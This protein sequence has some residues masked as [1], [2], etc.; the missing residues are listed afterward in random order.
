MKNTEN[1]EIRENMTV[2]LDGLQHWKSHIDDNKIAYWTLD[3]ADASVNTLSIDVMNEL[4]KLIEVTENKSSELKGV[5]ITSGKTSGF[6]AGADIQQFTVMTTFDE[7]FDII[8]KGQL[9]FE[10][11]S[12]L[13]L[14]TVA[15]INGF[16]MGGGTELSLACDY[17]IAKDDPKTRIGLPEVKLGI[18]PG[19]G[20]TIRL[21][22]LMGVLNAMNMILTGNPVGIKEALRTGLIDAAVPERYLAI[23][24]KKMIL[25][26]P[27]PHHPTWLEKLPNQK[28]L[29]KWV[30]KLLRKKVSKHVRK[31]HY[32]AP[33]AVIDLWEK[34][35]CTSKMALENE[36]KSIAQL[37]TSVG[38]QNL[39]RVFFL[40]NQLKNLGK[41]FSSDTPSQ[42]RPAKFNHV[43]VVGAGVMGGDIAAWCA[44]NGLKVTLQDREAKYIAP[45]IKRAY[46]LFKAKL[47]EERLVQETMDRLIPDLNGN[48]IS[49]A[50]I[51]IEA[52]IEETQ[53]KQAL[54]QLLEEKAK[55]HALLA[56]NTS[57]IPLSKIASVMKNPERIIGIHYFNPVAKMPLVEIVHEAN[58][59]KNTIQQA[60]AF[61]RQ[62]DKLPLIVK[63]A[64]GFLV[65][66]V[67]MPYLLEALIILNEGHSPEL[68]DEAALQFGMPMG[69]IEL[70]D[71]VGID[72][73]LSVAKYLLL[74]NQAELTE[75]PEQYQNMI[76]NLEKRIAQKKL[77]R[78][79]GEGFYVYK[80][81]KPQKKVFDKKTHPDLLNNIS[82][83]LILRMINESMACLREEIVETKDFLDAGMIFGTGFAPFRGGPLHYAE[84]FGIVKIVSALKDLE[85]KYGERFS[86]DKAWL[87]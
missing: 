38:A 4:D 20:G 58:T 28:L 59:D 12:N 51:I 10:R 47:K 64:P 52:I 66:R 53:A 60:A 67:L 86:P 37:I 48:G 54:F 8:R 25:E 3:R 65:N 11:L 23:A 42:S 75:L 45:A 27:T 46:G 34:D 31:E 74:S 76:K 61:V 43:H 56:T 82:N 72:V 80:N 44:L 17:R 77:G 41:Q 15:V 81:N 6:I 24:A 30:A 83:R 35:G 84:Q 73:C 9:I 49:Q 62:I 26:K 2:F 79:T 1:T 33:Y 39:I 16:C 14:P 71:T 19:W 36:A 21:P 22:L 32:P 69:P 57:G 55:P 63:S 87:E 5:V 18:Q 85:Q 13:S 50:D 78:K 7:A 70:T 29:R 68:I 40:Q